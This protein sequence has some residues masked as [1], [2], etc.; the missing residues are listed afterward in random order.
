M[1]IEGSLLRPVVD[2]SGDLDLCARPKV[3]G[4]VAIP[5]LDVAVTAIPINLTT[6]IQIFGITILKA[7]TSGSLGGFGGTVSTPPDKPLTLDV[8]GCL[9][10]VARLN[11]KNLQLP[12]CC[13]GYK[14]PVCCCC[15]VHK[16]HQYCVPQ[17]KCQ[18]AAS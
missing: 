16:A 10:A 2:I 1:K 5:E 7:L 6:K 17:C 4:K 15:E 13:E 12:V 14:E 11:P 8:D 9:Q 3:S 18:A